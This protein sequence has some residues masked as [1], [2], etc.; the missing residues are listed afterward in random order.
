MNIKNNKALFLDRDGVLILDK[1]YLKKEEDVQLI[2]NV[3]EALLKA[4]NHNYYLFLFTNQSGISRGYFNLDT[5]KKCNQKMI[6]LININKKI[7]TEICIAPEI[8]IDPFSYRKPSPRFILEM[9]N[10]YNLNIK[11]CWMIGDRITDLQAGINA[12]IKSVLINNNNNIEQNTIDYIEKNKKN[13]F[14]FKS[15]IEFVNHFI[16]KKL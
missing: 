8:K 3:S 14:V 6:N 1:H 11:E 10:K 15:L 9:I 16:I 2:E 4:L 5:V 7:F 12:N 13:I